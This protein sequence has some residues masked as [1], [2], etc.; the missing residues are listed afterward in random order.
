MVKLSDDDQSYRKITTQNCISK[1]CF[2]VNAHLNGMWQCGI[3]QIFFV[4]LRDTFF[5]SGY[6][7]QRRSQIKCEC[8][9][10]TPLKGKMHVTD[11]DDGVL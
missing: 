1:T 6:L 11:F 2:A 9:T 10:V 3:G 5:S 8:V 7:H 4:S